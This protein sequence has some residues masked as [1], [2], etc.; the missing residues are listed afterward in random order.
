MQNDPLTVISQ[1][2]H[3]F[4]QYAESIT[5]FSAFHPSPT[6]T[7]TA[8]SDMSPCPPLFSLTGALLFIKFL[9][10]HDRKY[11]VYVLVQNASLSSFYLQVTQDSK[12]KLCGGLQGLRQSLLAFNLHSVSELN[13]ITDSSGLYKS[14]SI[15]KSIPINLQVFVEDCCSLLKHLSCKYYC[16]SKHTTPFLCFF[17]Q[18][19]VSHGLYKLVS[20]SKLY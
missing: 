3:S 19:L 2:M 14:I 18:Y 20:Y 5:K 16:H 1:A 12:F 6:H 13:I 9:T 17:H 8:V 10:Y 15:K 7:I 11:Y 4:N